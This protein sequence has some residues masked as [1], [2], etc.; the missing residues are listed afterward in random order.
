VHKPTTLENGVH[1]LERSDPIRQGAFHDHDI[2]PA[3][4]LQRPYVLLRSET[5]G[6]STGSR[7]KRGFGRHTALDHPLEF[8][9]EI[10]QLPKVAARVRARQNLDSGAEAKRSSAIKRVAAARNVTLA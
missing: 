5:L 8:V 3:T 1:T 6:S 2:T 9:C 4:D 7:Q 10:A